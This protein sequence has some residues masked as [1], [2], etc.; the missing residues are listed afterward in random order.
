MS[1]HPKIV[2]LNQVI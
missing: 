2:Q 1:A